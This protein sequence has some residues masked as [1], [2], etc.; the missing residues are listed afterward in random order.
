M[1]DSATRPAQAAST[2]RYAYK[3][4]LIGAAHQFELTET[5]LSWRLAG[6]SG[7]WPYAD[8][9]TIRL[10]Y[11][12]VSMQSHRFRA[13]LRHVAGGRISIVSTN[14]QTAALMAPQD[15]LYRV[16]VRELL[17]RTQA[18]G[19]RAALSGGLSRKA[20]TAAFVLIAAIGIALGGLLIR[21]ITTGQL[22]GAAFVV[23]FATLFGWQIG[24]FM[25]RNRPTAHSF[26]DIPESLLP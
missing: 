21:A 14:W 20:Y 25:R 11:R 26:D 5:G 15:E 4:S 18:A 19:S 13:D 7:V 9:A 1:Q 23:G 16:F 17:A 8:I 24:G 12:P 6:R 22:A 2:T 10:S 3:A